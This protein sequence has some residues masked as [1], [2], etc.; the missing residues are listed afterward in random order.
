MTNSEDSQTE[1]INK[2]F[3][4]QLH[5]FERQQKQ[6]Q[7][8]K[9]RE[10]KDFRTRSQHL[11]ALTRKYI[12]NYDKTMRNKFKHIQVSFDYSNNRKDK[13]VGKHFYNRV[14]EKHEK[15][16]TSKELEEMGHRLLDWFRLEQAEA[17]SHHKEKRNS[18]KK[19][20]RDASECICQAPV[21]WQ[22][23]QF[24]HNAD[25]QLS[26]SELR[27]IEHNGYEHCVAPFINACDYNKDTRLSEREWCCC[28][29]S[30][31][32]PC[33][34]AK[35]KV[36][37]LVSS[38]VKKVLVGAYV[39]QCDANGFYTPM[40]CHSSIGQCWCVNKHGHEIRNTRTSGELNCGEN[41]HHSRS[42]GHNDHVKE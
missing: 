4:R 28:F 9:Q 18:K 39:P 42:S 27:Y 23:R 36:T 40:Q 1:C 33:L 26:E 3:L 7:K 25:G 13:M 20:L 35:N 32:P 15:E 21:T 24:D 16:C 11:K 10:P 8:M 34:T 30:I 38:G 22:F 19:E 5:R 17:L 41:R 37:A 12:A 31:L 6:Q 29:A 2:K 14:V